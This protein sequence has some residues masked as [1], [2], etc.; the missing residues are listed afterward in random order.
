MKH[1]LTYCIF[2][3]FVVF[4]FNVATPVIHAQYDEA[5]G[6]INNEPTSHFV[7]LVGIPYVD[8][9]QDISL[10]DYVNSLYFAAISIAAF[11]AVLKIIFAGVQYMLTDVTTTKGDAKKTIRGALLGLLIVLGAV[12]ILTTINPQLANLNVLNLEEIVM[13]VNP[14]PED[15]SGPAALPGETTGSSC[16][17]PEQIERFSRC[18]TGAVMTPGGH[19]GCMNFTCPPTD[20]E[21]IAEYCPADRECRIEPCDRENKGY[22]ETCA[23]QCDSRNGV[24]Y[25][26]LTDSCVS[27]NEQDTVNPVVT[28]PT[29]TYYIVQNEDDLAAGDPPVEITVLGTSATNGLVEVRLEDG[30]IVEYS[31][32]YITPSVCTQ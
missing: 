3:F 2:I 12:L 15:R 30:T 5:V 7:P 16:A 31:C 26:H 23:A 6:G 27:T 4:C 11:L 1:F 14:P 18:S 21:I 8:T 22:L 9:T 17:T 25:D 20:E 29:T 10:G 13:P 24:H 19:P 28:E 32:A